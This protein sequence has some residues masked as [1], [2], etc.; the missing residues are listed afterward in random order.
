MDLVAFIL[1]PVLATLSLLV[2][3]SPKYKGR[4][5]RVAF[6]IFGIP[7][8][9]FFLDE[10]LGQTYLHARCAAEGGIQVT[11]PIQASG[12]FSSEKSSSVHDG[13]ELLCSDAL[14]H[15]KFQYFETD[16]RYRYPYYTDQQ[17]VHR[18]YLADK[19]SGLCSM[20]G[21]QPAGGWGK[22][23]SDKCIA[24]T[25]L[26]EPSSRYEVGSQGGSIGFFPFKLI[27]TYRYVKDRATDKIV[28][29]SVYLMYW[30]GWVRNSSLGHNSAS[31]CPSYSESNG[32]IFEKIIV[33]QL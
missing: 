21:Q 9:V 25:R 8:L 30:G 24:F 19:E 27:R 33:P 7:F 14:L 23:P 6:T 22:I 28:G 16:V 5:F 13:C 10:I 32:A 4:K 18:F 15:H 2:F 17:G 31:V 1:F 11:E 26:P 29:S 20:E 12:Y 3:L